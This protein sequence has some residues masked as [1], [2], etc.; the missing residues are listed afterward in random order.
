ML[1]SPAWPSGAKSTTYP[2]RT[3]SVSSDSRMAASSSMIKMRGDVSGDAAFAFVCG[4]RMPASDMDRF[5]CRGEFQMECGAVPDLALYLNLARM[6]LDDA[7]AD[8]QA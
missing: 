5:P 2:S 8:L 7:I 6:L 4:A 1:R 3:R